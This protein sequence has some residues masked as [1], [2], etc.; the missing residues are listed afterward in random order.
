[1]KRDSVSAYVHLR[2]DTPLPMYAPV[3]ILDDP[4][5]IS[6]VTHILNGWSISERKDK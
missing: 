6:I 3:R 4:R 5:S 2:R 1:M